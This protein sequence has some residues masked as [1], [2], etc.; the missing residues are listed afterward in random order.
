MGVVVSTGDVG[1]VATGE[2]RGVVVVVTAPAAGMDDLREINGKVDARLQKTHT[3]AVRGRP[4]TG[5]LMTSTM[6][7]PTLRMMKSLARKGVA[8]KLY[9]HIGVSNR[10]CYLCSGKGQCYACES[11]E[12]SEQ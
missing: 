1:A 11:E 9:A 5:V 7:P 10:L 6:D 2:T 8:V 12:Q 3:V 4:L